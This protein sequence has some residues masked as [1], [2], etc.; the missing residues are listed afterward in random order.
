M[1]IGAPHARAADTTYNFVSYPSLQNGYTLSGTIITNGTFGPLT[2]ADVVSWTW[3]IT[4]GVNT[5]SQSGANLD[6]GTV[7]L[8]ATPTQ[9]LVGGS[10]GQV[11][12]QGPPNVYLEY[13]RGLKNYDA[14]ILGGLRASGCDSTSILRVARLA[15]RP[16]SNR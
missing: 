8:E 4:D 1:A 13:A 9:L 14:A 10:S 16:H 12:F 2:G 11:V 5:D 3:T 15:L 7:G 6:P